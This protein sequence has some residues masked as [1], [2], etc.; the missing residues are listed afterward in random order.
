VQLS[1][2]PQTD[3]S[4]V[5]VGDHTAFTGFYGSDVV[6]RLAGDFS[7]EIR[8]RPESKS[9]CREVVGTDAIRA[10]PAPARTG[11]GKRTASG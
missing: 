9:L 7:G 2:D 11:T 1:A 8:V 4:A 6:P 3:Y 10:K 5:T